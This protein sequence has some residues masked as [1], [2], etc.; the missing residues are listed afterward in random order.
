MA[1]SAPVPTNAELELLRYLWRDGPRTV[2]Q[3]HREVLADRAVGY[4]TVLK[5]LQVMSEKGL[6]TRDESARSHVYKAAV[7]ENAVKKQLVSDLVDRAFDGSAARLVMQ[8]LSTKRAPPDELRE[9]RRFLDRLN[10]GE[11]S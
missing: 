11:R 8:A 10:R 7:P 1:T 3:L 6:V 5:T 9:I 2:S 4:T